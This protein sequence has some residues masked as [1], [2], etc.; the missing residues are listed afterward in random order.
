M[1]KRLIKFPS[2]EQFR[3][4]IRDVEHTAQ[5]IGQDPETDEPI[6]NRGAKL[7]TITVGATEK[8]HG[9]NM[10]VCFSVQDG[11]WVQSREN[12]ITTESDNA[13][14]AFNAMQNKEAWIAIIYALATE[15]SIN[16][17][18]HIISVYAEWCGGNIQSK[19]AASGL[20]KM[21]VIFRHF[22]VSPV[23]NTEDEDAVWFETK[24]K[25][26]W[27]EFTEKRI[28]NINKFPTYE[29]VIDFNQPMFS[30]N[31]LVDLVENTIEPN[32]PFG[33][34]FGIDGNIG[35]GIVCTFMLNGSLK[36][37]KVKGS[38]HSASKVKTLKPV[39]NEKMQQIQDL[40]QSVTPAWRLEQMFALANDT[41]N[42]SSPVIQNMGMFLKLL[43]QDIL[44][45]ESDVIAEAGFE[46]KEVFP[47]VAKIAKQWYNEELNR[48]VFKQ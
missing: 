45:E 34:Q 44:K 16:L 33:R 17:N 22:K 15:H 43:N 46:P 42:G 29:F 41:A 2:I 10:A 32:S 35:E 19:S 18:T 6:Y 11:F 36:Q 3:S 7:P 38:K 4:V 25:D 37:F 1:T 23:E 28:F 30:Q 13:G 14:C 47:V 31:A 40:A 20:E 21:T 8:L 12:I 26:Q 9:T 24:A 39:D 5:Y 27:V 48:L